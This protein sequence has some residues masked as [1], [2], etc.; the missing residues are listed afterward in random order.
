MLSLPHVPF[1]RDLVFGARRNVGRRRLAARQGLI[2]HIVAAL[3]CHNNS[4]VCEI[5]RL[6][7]LL[8]TG[9]VTVNAGIVAAEAI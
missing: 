7:H 5:R 8:D 9:L 1:S 4:R 6:R 3:L 2:Y